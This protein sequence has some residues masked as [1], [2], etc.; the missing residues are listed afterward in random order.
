[1]DQPWSR[2]IIAS[3]IRFRVDEA[4]RQEGI[5]IPFP[6]RDVHVIPSDAQ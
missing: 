2:R 1:V 5:R 3:N 4:F 6:Q